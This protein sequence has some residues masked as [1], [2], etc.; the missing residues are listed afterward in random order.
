MSTIPE[1]G[2]RISALMADLAARENA[3]RTAE[4]GGKGA[5]DVEGIRAD[6]ARITAEIENLRAEIGRHPDRR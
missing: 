5:A 4:A 2:A 1:L 6:V 3:L